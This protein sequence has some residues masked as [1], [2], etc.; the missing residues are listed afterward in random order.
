MRNDKLN[1]LRATVQN[2]DLALLSK[3]TE[4]FCGADIIISDDPNCPDSNG[5]SVYVKVVTPYAKELSWLIF[6]LKDIFKDDL[7]YLNKYHFY[8]TL[9]ESANAYVEKNSNDLKGLLL[10]VIDSA[11]TIKL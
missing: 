9:A 4:L 3:E 8:G 10:F 1:N 6:Q 7:D 5:W 2:S 11:E